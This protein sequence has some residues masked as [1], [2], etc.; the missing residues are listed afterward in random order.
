M[1]A[2]IEFNIANYNTDTEII[3]FHSNLPGSH[4]LLKL[5]P[6]LL[7]SNLLLSGHRDAPAFSISFLLKYC[8]V[9]IVLISVQVVRAVYNISVN[10]PT[11][12]PVEHAKQLSLT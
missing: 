4:I 6:L 2:G 3:N 8:A 1:L 9:I 12:N 7:L 5:L 10:D 11:R